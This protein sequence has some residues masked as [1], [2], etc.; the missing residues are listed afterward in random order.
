MEL[1]MTDDL[2]IYEDDNCKAERLAQPYRPHHSCPVAKY[3]FTDKTNGVKTL[4]SNPRDLGTS[5]H[6]LSGVN[7]MAAAGPF[8]GFGEYVP[9]SE[10]L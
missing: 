3:L 6:R 4:A 2:T 5:I 10:V 1:K 9:L 8:D 7:P